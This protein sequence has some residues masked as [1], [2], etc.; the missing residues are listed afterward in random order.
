M[1]VLFESVS[2]LVG[3][4]RH[5]ILMTG[6]GNDGAK[7]MAEAK[8]AGACSTIAESKETCVVFGMPKSAIERKCVDYIV[9]V[10]H[11]AAK[12]LEVTGL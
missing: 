9:P 6:M 3:L 5:Y 11:I 4:K 1:D 12:I 10:N 8:Q 7:G 2:K